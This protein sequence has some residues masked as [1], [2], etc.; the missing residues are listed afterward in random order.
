MRLHVFIFVVL[1]AVL[2][3][4]QNASA[5]GQCV[6]VDCNSV[7]T[8]C[9]ALLDLDPVTCGVYY[10][11]CYKKSD[12][13][14]I[15]DND[16]RANPCGPG[17]PN[18]YCIQS[19]Q[20]GPLQQGLTVGS[21]QITTNASPGASAS[22][23]LSVMVARRA[24]GTVLYN[25]WNL[26]QG[27][28]GWQPLDASVRTNA[29]PAAALVGTYLFVIIR[30]QDGYLYLNQ[31][32]VNKSFVGWKRMDFQSDVA[33]SATAS[34]KTTV[35]VARDKRGRLFYSSWELGQGAS[36]WQEIVGDVPTVSTPAAAL[37]G[38]YLFV[39][40]KGTDGSLYL[41]QGGLNKKF[42][43]WQP[44]GFESNVAAGATSAGETSV[45]VAKDS[46]G[47]VSYNW[48][49]V[50]EGGKGWKSLADNVR[51][52]MAPAASLVG[53]YLFVAITGRD[54]HIY[55]NQGNLGQPFVGWK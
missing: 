50:G 44:M 36:A 51:T 17:C 18:D 52:D 29:A 43:G 48:W 8:I 40:A 5:A 54:G 31:G 2:S 3:P 23:V 12:G 11:C 55:L 19:G 20:V 4:I 27:A 47:R 7:Q 26:G 46:Q 9:Y 28:R 16:C 39:V 42:V 6:N 10:G 37:V 35:L 21:P 45:V 32:T 41:S 22:G 33:P 14:P 24:D 1:S 49:N 25:W 15:G 34:G 53:D 30:G 38:G 13:L